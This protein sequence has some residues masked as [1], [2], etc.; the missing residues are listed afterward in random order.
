MSEAASVGAVALACLLRLEVVGTTA[1][2][3]RPGDP[4]TCEPWHVVDR[5]TNV[6]L[7]PYWTLAEAMAGRAELVGETILYHLQQLRKETP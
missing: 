3:A 7:G 1:R 2:N 6:R 4:P 5:R